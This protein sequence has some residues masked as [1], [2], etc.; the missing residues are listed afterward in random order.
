MTGAARQYR[1]H[2]TGQFSQA[3]FRAIGENVVFE[4]GALVFHPEN[5]SLGAN[6]YVGHYAILKG[7]YRNL[8]VIG[9]NTWIGQNAFFHSAGGLTIGRNVGIGPGVQIITSFHED[10]GVGVP[11]LFS[12][13]KE[14]PVTIEDDCD[15]GVGSIILPGVRIGHST[16]I[17]AG[18]VV[19]RDV[20]PCSVIAGSP[21]RV[22]RQRAE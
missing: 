1:S 10:A 6:I 11:I 7:Y 21:A 20:P 17:G 22:L 18:S 13:V 14:G 9:D 4:P 8:M 15:I 19:T 5:I 2:G 12:P 16:Q 3:D